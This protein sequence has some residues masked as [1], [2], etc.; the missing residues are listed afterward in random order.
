MKPVIERDRNHVNVNL[1]KPFLLWTVAFMGVA[2]VTG[3]YGWFWVAAA[4][5]IVSFGFAFLILGVGA[6]A[7]FLAYMA[8]KPIQVTNKRKDTVR[9]VQR[10][11]RY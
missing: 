2:L 4:P 9:T 3:S 8:G 11:R 10:K 5:W 6:L 7:M 1:T